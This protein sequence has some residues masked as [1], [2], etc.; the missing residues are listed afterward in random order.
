M[1][2][3]RLPL[4]PPLRSMS[5]WFA[6]P[7]W[8]LAA[9]AALAVWWWLGQPV[10]MADVALERVPCLSYAPFRGRQ[11][12]FD[13]DLIIPRQQIEEDLRALKPVT[14]CVRTYAVNQG[15]AE[16]PRIA[17][18]LGMTVL[19]GVWIGAE[20]ARNYR[21]IETA[22]ALARH[23]PDTVK[24]LVVGNEVL[25]R[26]EQPAAALIA[27]IQRVKAAVPVPVTYADV[28]E[29]W[30]RNP[31]VAPA[32][33][34]VTIHTLPYWEDDPVAI[35][36]AV[37]HV[38]ATWARVQALFPEKPVFIGEAG[39][40]SAGR[41]RED[42]LPSLLNQTRFTREILRLAAEKGF[43]VNLVEAFDQP[44]KRKFEGTVGGHWGLVDA[45]R[46]AK[47]TLKGPVEPHP[48]WPKRFAVAAALAGLGML[49]I[50]RVARLRP[51]AWLG[52][53]LSAH[54]AAA[55]LV[56]AWGDIEAQSRT[57]AE[58]A[59]GLAQLALAAAVPA[60][61]ALAIAAGGG[62]FVPAHTLLAALQVRRLPDA[63]PL[64]IALSALRLAVLVAAAA[65]SLALIAD[66]RYRDF[67]VALYAGPALALASLTAWGTG[68]PVG[69]DRRE[70]RLLAWL[71]A[72]A[73]AVV[74]LV[75]GPRNVQALAW[76]VTASVIALSILS[77][78]PS[79]RR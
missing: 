62:T 36:D 42:A 15:L 35:A 34:F 22:I 8:L 48:G 6:F 57:L 50:A 47:V 9:L 66:P 75:E 18:G 59:L 10:P 26:Q 4:Q 78:R 79:S 40:P 13:R 25:L 30:E 63:A 39:W 41:M 23:Y 12:P 11:A 69:A 24:A 60:L 58:W 77:H 45:D 46:R 51:L 74:A 1:V 55:A 67:P 7:A 68:F 76:L 27:M 5:H 2:V 17:Q 21:E 65:H 64:A 31:Q 14:A 16:V 33:D 19:Q 32:V 72:A 3:R 61:A 43:G 53:A 73:G 52:L 71:L 29:F 37:P 44:W 56:I 28:W 49:A 38:G 54:A 20:A 70:E